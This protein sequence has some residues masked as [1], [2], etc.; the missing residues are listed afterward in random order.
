MQPFE[1]TIC[2][3]RFV[4]NA[5]LK[6][7]KVSDHEGKTP[8][9]CTV[10]DFFMKQTRLFTAN[11][12][13]LKGRHVASVHEGKQPFQC[14]ARGASFTQN[15]DSKNHKTSVHEG[16]KPFKCTICVLQESEKA[17]CISS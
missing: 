9:E 7:K 6:V 8:F 17:I 15:A 3:A 13:H 1:C 2:G 11:M 12:E 5:N 14:N 16:K 4:D 10:Y